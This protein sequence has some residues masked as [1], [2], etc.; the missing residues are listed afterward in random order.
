VKQAAERDAMDALAD[1]GSEDDSGDS[2]GSDGGQQT[3][4]PQ[5][6]AKRQRGSDVAEK[7]RAEKDFRNPK[8]LE[9][10][11]EKLQ[12][13][14]PTG[15]NLRYQAEFADWEKNLFLQAEP[16]GECSNAGDNLGEGV[17]ASDLVQDQISRAM[18]PSRQQP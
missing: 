6:S 15:T 5:P 1:Y 14:N 10:I 3:A 12:I 7:L 2:P 18:G 4:P 16:A 11:V 9:Q 13:Q 17:K 8:R